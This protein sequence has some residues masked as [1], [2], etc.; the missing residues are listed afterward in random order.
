MSGESKQTD[1]AITSPYV[2]DIERLRD[3]ILQTVKAARFA[4]L[5]TAI[6]EGWSRALG[7]REDA[8]LRGGN[9]ARCY[10]LPL[11]GAAHAEPA[12]WT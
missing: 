8:L 4:T 11:A 2:P 10:G 1:P 9:A 12:R 6:V 7:A 3:W 5:V